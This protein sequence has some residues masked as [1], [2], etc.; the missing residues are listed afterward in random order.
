M[1]QEQEQRK[2]ELQRKTD[3]DRTRSEVAKE[4][5]QK[6]KARKSFR[7]CLDSNSESCSLTPEG[8]PEECRPQARKLSIHKNGDSEV[9]QMAKSFAKYAPMNKDDEKDKKEKNK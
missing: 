8:Y 7:E 9:V 3:E 2:A 5:Q 4:E 1:R 6:V